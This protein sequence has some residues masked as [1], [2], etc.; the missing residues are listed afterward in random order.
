[1]SAPPGALGSAA[2]KLIALACAS[3]TAPAFSLTYYVS[4]SSALA[5]DT[6][7]GLVNF[8]P[9]ETLRGAALVGIV[10]DGC[11]PHVTIRLKRGDRWTDTSALSALVI[12]A[13]GAAGYKL[14]IGA[15][16]DASLPN[17]IID[18]RDGSGSAFRSG[19]ML[20]DVCHVRIEDLTIRGF[21]FGISVE[22]KCRDIEIDRVK[23][24]F[25]GRAGVQVSNIQNCL[26]RDGCG[27]P[28]FA[29][30]YP[31]GV[32]VS[33]CEF[34]GNGVKSDSAQVGIGTCATNVTIRGCTLKGSV[35]GGVNRGVAG[36]V[37]TAASSGHEI[38]ENIFDHHRLY[39]SGSS[40]GRGQAIVL[41]DVHPRT[42][43]S[44]LRTLI[45]NN[46]IFYN[47]GGGIE[48]SGGT[49][50]VYIYRNAIYRNGYNGDKDGEKLGRG[51]Y[52]QPGRIQF[53]MDTDGVSPWLDSP[54]EAFEISNIQIFRNIIY[55]N[56]RAGIE[57][58]AKNGFQAVR[59]EAD[60]TS[61]DGGCVV[62]GNN[63]F[64]PDYRYG[65]LISNIGIY[66]NTIARNGF[67]G[68]T[69]WRY[70]TESLADD[71]TNPL[72]MPPSSDYPD[73]LGIGDV[74]IVSNILSKNGTALN[75]GSLKSYLMQVSISGLS[76]G[77]P[78]GM[79][80][81]WGLVMDHNWYEMPDVAETY[82]PDG[83]G[84][85]YE[86]IVLWNNGSRV[87]S[88]GLWLLN[89]ETSWM[90][91]FA[92]MV[93]S[94]RFKPSAFPLG[95]LPSFPTFPVSGGVD[96]EGGPHACDD[97]GF[98]LGEASPCIDE[99]DSALGID[100]PGSGV[101]VGLAPDYCGLG[102][103]GVLDVGALEHIRIP[104]EPVHQGRADSGQARQE[105]QSS[106][107][108]WSASDLLQHLSSARMALRLE[109]IMEMDS[110]VR[111]ESCPA[112]R[113]LDLADESSA[114]KLQT[115]GSCA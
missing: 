83:S 73:Y 106:G 8:R 19:L 81:L 39:V 20:R 110:C 4:N 3:C 11:K 47:E 74:R 12:G 30:D 103:I 38:S 18:G 50:G 70:P 48:I 10:D 42:Q 53:N 109:W 94:P 57:V 95:S 64:E 90:T 91:G 71:A 78:H 76:R 44:G 93:G 41:S 24:F 9:W 96:I 26:Q 21:D 61:T 36:I 97:H 56:L 112:C 107:S 29:A 69:I 77:L 67:E 66:N 51:I 63:E 99:G 85:Y 17:P 31:S 54:K 33:N 88:S 105:A 104:S 92:D 15:W 5:S 49:R 62:R 23:F 46:Q 6:N 101:D 25:N 72:Y 75:A 22:G 13:S 100:D 45:H 14:T 58:T 87:D 108:E 52:I 82:F 113:L 89:R 80:E 2:D 27:S 60:P 1:M 59:V 111:S 55:H 68:I 115:C 65:G 86:Y 7:S 34:Q 40:Y 37:I 35:W 84:S 28:G 102:P 16:G 98:Y 79:F 114:I 32:T 43:L